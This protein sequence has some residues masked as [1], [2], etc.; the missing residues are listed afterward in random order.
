VSVLGWVNGFGQ[1]LPPS[2]IQGV[3]LALINSFVYVAGVI[4]VMFK[5][6]KSHKY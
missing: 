5:V 6:P 4:G 1:I 3:W 2:R